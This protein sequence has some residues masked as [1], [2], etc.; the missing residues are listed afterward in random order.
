M[1]T[2]PQLVRKRSSFT[3][4]Q[5]LEICRHY[6]ANPS[7]T[8]NQLAAWVQEAFQLP[9]TPS[10]ATISKVLKRKSEL[11]AAT[12]AMLASRTKR[13]VRLPE[14][15]AAL[16]RW[17]RW[18]ESRNVPLTN[19]KIKAKAARFAEILQAET[20]AMWSNGWLQKFCA[21]HGIKGYKSQT[22]PS[23]TAEPLVSEVQSKLQA[24]EHRDVFCVGETG[25]LYAVTPQRRSLAQA[26]KR[27]TIALACNAD[28]SER[29]PPLFVGKAEKPRGFTAATAVGFTYTNSGRGLMTRP[30][31]EKWIKEIDANFRMQSRNCVL[32]LDPVAV[33]GGVVASELTNT[34]LVFLPQSSAGSLQPL[35]AGIINAFKIRYRKRQIEQA[36]DRIDAADVVETDADG[37]PGNAYTVNV[38]QALPWCLES[39]NTIPSSLIVDSWK[40]VGLLDFPAGELQL[41]Q[42]E[43]AISD[44]LTTILT[45]LHQDDPL[46]LEELLNSAE[47]N[48]IEDE[49][50]DEFF[51]GI[52]ECEGV[53]GE[54]DA[55]GDRDLSISEIRER[56]KWIGTLFIT[57]ETRGVQAN[58][59]SGLRV[60]QRQL[61]EELK[62]KQAQERV[63]VDI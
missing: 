45:F 24:Y 9:R 35:H 59:L 43:L 15:D 1:P 21:R 37:V 2:E 48:V 56:L 47:E 34:E 6:E 4:A 10:Q 11:E 20:K 25:L 30:I 26:K 54:I 50:S 49:P 40:R 60:L 27:L 33:H 14:V 58:T 38:C 31:F 8:Q 55:D 19:D 57:A 16:V 42:Q 18:C 5:R 52:E 44:E 3:N 36:L 32:L 12:P 39:W 41:S 7:L 13:H 23:I 63:K 51:C 29:L 53:E 22:E 17:I 28:G 46:S 62:V 61:R